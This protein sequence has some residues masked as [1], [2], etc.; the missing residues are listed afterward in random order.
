MKKL[1]FLVV[2]SLL[3]ILNYSMISFAEETPDIVGKSSILIDY[4]T[5]QILY[6]KISNEKFYPSSTTKILAAL[7]ILENH[8]LDEIVTVDSNSPFVEGS[9]I[10]IFENEEL[11]VEQLLKSMLV[12][13]ANDCAEALA[14]Y[15]SG[16]IEAFSKEMN[17]K[18]KEIGALNS[19]FINPHGLHDEN[20]YTTAYDL[21]LIAREAYK[22][23]IFQEI[24]KMSTYSIEPTEYQEE[25][26]YMHTTNKFLNSTDLIYYKGK[27]ITAKYNI[28]DGI[29]TGYTTVS[30]NNLVS[31][32]QKNGIRL[33]SVVFKSD[34][35]NIYSDSRALL[36]YGFDNYKYHSFTFS[37][38][39]I[40]SIPIENGTK[41]SADLFSD[42]TITGL[43]PKDFNIENIDEVINTNPITL[44]ISEDQVLGS[45]EYHVGDQLI[46]RSD[47]I[48]DE[49]IIEKTLF[50]TL[51]NHLIKKNGLGQIE[52]KYYINIIINI[53]ISFVIWR[54][55]VTISRIRNRKKRLK[56]YL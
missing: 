25:T 36:D 22:N 53:L 44:P 31:T 5:G 14:V 56:K 21:S 11:T 45:I 15:H 51:Q 33:I 37:G 9:K 28:V 38:N 13:S 20:H 23:P 39:K 35:N 55:I 50:I 54:T 41:N 10:F 29:K 6:E 24:V 4:S 49:D 48:T 18:A 27:Y 34:P 3:L 40:T 47:L 17:E 32:A 52:Y 43:I 42:K 26:R 46:G 8:H 12:A 16:S 30:K 7:I 19:N 1:Y 2:L